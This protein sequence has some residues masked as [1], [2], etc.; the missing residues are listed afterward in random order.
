MGPLTSHYVEDAEGFELFNK[1][2][3]R[4]ADIP[5]ILRDFDS[6]QI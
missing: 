1:A 5:E 4:Q 2:E 3:I 6:V